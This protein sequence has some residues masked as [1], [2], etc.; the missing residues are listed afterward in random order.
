MTELAA[1]TYFVADTTRTNSA[2]QAI[3]ALYRFDGT[4]AQELVDGVEDLQ[5]EYAL[6]TAITA[7]LMPSPIPGGVTQLGGC[8]GGAGIAAAEQRERGQRG[9][10]TL[11]LFPGRQY[12]DQSAHPPTFA[13]ARNS[14]PWSPSATACFREHSGCET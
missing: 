10:C 5:I 12:S 7:R 2:G 8:D 6:D 4:T 13:C 11:H 9:Q 1:H 3:M 14:P